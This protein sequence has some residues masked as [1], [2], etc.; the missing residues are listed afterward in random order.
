MLM[1]HGEAGPAINSGKDGRT[2]VEVGKL[3]DVVREIY[4]LGSPFELSIASGGKSRAHLSARNV[5]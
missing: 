3:S 2:R 1:E 4:E 5:H